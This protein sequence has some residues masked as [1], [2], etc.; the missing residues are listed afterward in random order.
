MT[1]SM[2]AMLALVAALAAPAAF[3]QPAKATWDLPAG[4][5]DAN[6]HTQNLRWFAA[7]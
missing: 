5:N 6:F 2:G 7:R 3:A 4:Y 1:R